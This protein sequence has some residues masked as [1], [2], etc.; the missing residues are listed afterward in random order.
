MDQVKKDDFFN[1]W[2][3][4]TQ[5]PLRLI[6]LEKSVYF[7][8]ANSISSWA[9]KKWKSQAELIF[10]K[11]G[12]RELINITKNHHDRGVEF[13]SVQPNIQLIKSWQ[14]FLHSSD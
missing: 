7:L 8:I 5:L 13:G 2:T 6:I 9:S 4:T 10:E 3:Y 1:I 14:F 12:L 11:M